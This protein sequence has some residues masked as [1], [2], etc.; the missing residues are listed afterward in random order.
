MNDSGINDAGIN[1][2]EMNYGEMNYGGINGGGMNDSG[3]N[4]GSAKTSFGPVAKLF[5]LRECLN[6]IESCSATLPTHPGLKSGLTV[7][8]PLKWVKF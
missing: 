4:D 3:I 6:S 7:P 8:N 5:Q 1:D 2:G